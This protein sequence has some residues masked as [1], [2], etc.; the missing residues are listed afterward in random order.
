MMCFRCVHHSNKQIDL[1]DVSSVERVINTFTFQA[2]SAVCL[3]AARRP[4]P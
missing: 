4:A 1:Y 2:S 3:R